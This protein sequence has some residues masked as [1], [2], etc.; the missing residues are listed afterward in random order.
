MGSKIGNAA[1]L[2]HVGGPRRQ[3]RPAPP[4][5]TIPEPKLDD[6]VLSRTERKFAILRVD[7]DRKDLVRAR[8]V[9]R[10]VFGPVME[11]S[12]SN[13]SY[14]LAQARKEEGTLVNLT[15]VEV[16]GG[17]VERT[18]WVLKTGLSFQINKEG[19][20]LY[21]E[22]GEGGMAI[23]ANAD[24]WLLFFYYDAGRDGSGSDAG[25]LIDSVQLK[26]RRAEPTTST[27]G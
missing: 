19:L 21:G 2:S 8:L 3:A 20:I 14:L 6:A 15:G 1:D 7:G 5:A 24:G 9:D 4:A 25:N 22:E 26:L 12:V 13:G 17:E 18:G 27:G 16:N 10:N 11:A 23:P